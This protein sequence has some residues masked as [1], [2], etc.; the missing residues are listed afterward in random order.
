LLVALWTFTST[1]NTSFVRLAAFHLSNP[2]AAIHTL[3]GQHT[4]AATWY[5]DSDKRFGKEIDAERLIVGTTGSNR[6]DRFG[7]MKA[8]L[9]LA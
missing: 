1:L 6:R 4:I 5:E 2:L 8:G 9:K 3:Y 7:V